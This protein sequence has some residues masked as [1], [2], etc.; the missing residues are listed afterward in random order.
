M[1]EQLNEVVN[2]LRELPEDDQDV[3]AHQLI[4]LIEL[5]QSTNMELA[6]ASGVGLS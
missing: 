3:I 6:S 2:I 1:T 5:D 4:R